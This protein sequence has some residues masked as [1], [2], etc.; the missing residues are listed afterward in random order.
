VLLDLTT[1]LVGLSLLLAAYV[2]GVS[3]MGFPL[4]ATPTVALLLD[5]RT[6]VTIL[7]LPNILMDITQVVRGKFHPALFRRF[8]PL[9]LLTVVGVFLGTSVLVTLP[10]W[11]LN[12]T[13]GL[14]V[15]L[16]I[17]AHALRLQF[18][19]PAR[20][21][22]VASPLMGLVGGFLNGMTNAAGPALAIYL[23]SLRLPKTEFVKS[24]ATI[25][26]ITKV[27]QL[28]AVSTWNLLNART[29]RL[30]ILVTLFILAGFYAGLKTQDWID[31]QR[32]NRCLLGLLFVIGSALVLSA[33]R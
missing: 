20:W 28:A 6:A 21:E 24:I 27:S 32:F 16:F 10:L 4:I 26:V 29:L 5:I 12:L 15:L 25:F 8:A 17:A 2:K 11:I 22:K 23:Y 7:I 30:S 1:I 31:Q 9:L 3:G 13:L 18:Y 33:L 14:I 19:L